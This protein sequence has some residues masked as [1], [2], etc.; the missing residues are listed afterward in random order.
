MTLS[1]IAGLFILW[2]AVIL[3]RAVLLKPAENAGCSM[4]DFVPETNID[5]DEAAKRFSELIGCCTV[6]PENM[7]V[8]DGINGYSEFERF[9]ELLKVFYPLT[10]K[11]LEFELIGDHSLLYRWNGRNSDKPLLLMA[12]Y[13][14]VPAD[15]SQW[16]RPPFSGKIDQGIIWGRGTLDTKVT[17]CGILETVEALLNV[18]FKPDHDIYLAFGHDEETMGSGA[19]AIVETLKSRGIRPELVLDEGGAIVN[20]IFPGV[21]KPIAVVGMAEKGVAD[22]EIVLEGSGGHSSTP[23]RINPIGL[24]SKIILQVEKNPFRAH[25][26]LEVEEMFS[27]LGRHMPFTFRVV[28]ANLWCFKPLLLKL[29]PIISREFNAL[30]R[31]TCVFTM[32]E[33]GSASNVI[34]EKVRVVANLRLAAIDPIDKALGQINKHAGIASAKALKGS[35]PLKLNVRIIHGH[36]ASPSSSTSSSAF[37]KLAD[38]VEKVFTGTIVTPYIMLGASDSRHYCLISDNVLRF[39]PI[40][41][42]REELRSIH[43]IDERIPVEKFKQVIDFYLNLVTRP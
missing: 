29:L 17:L 40:Q 6:A 36:N 28:F 30:C 31:T 21:K 2:F 14:V 22:I 39:S 19:P 25:L 11:K 16:S 7:P 10:H 3:L 9:R 4:P 37:R 43:G 24:I 35:D 42:S 27:I 1:I 5:M 8:K 15:E 32:A 38:T 34:P 12:H 26:P 23:G 13:D 41:M 33:A 20:G 18:D